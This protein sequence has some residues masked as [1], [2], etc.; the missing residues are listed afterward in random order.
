MQNGSPAI[1]SNWMC[2]V[3]AKRYGQNAKQMA[4]TAAAWLTRSG[5]N[6]Q[7]IVF[8]GSG[9]CHKS[10]VPARITR[11]VHIPVLS[12]TP[13]QA[14]QLAG[15]EDKQ[16]YVAQL[17]EQVRAAP[18]NWFNFFDYWLD[19]DSSRNAIAAH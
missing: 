19:E 17:E 2:A 15:F 7:L 8:A 10:A 14:S 12:V 11:R 9:H 1:I 16:R 13:V 6:S 5:D 4:D 3:C 18:F